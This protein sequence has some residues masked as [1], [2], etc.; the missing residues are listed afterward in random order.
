MV[1]YLGDK[2]GIRPGEVTPDGLF[3]LV[4]E[5]C[6]A[7]CCGAPMLQINDR[8]YENLTP[9][10]LDALIAKCRAEA[11]ADSEAQPHA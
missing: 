10:S 5:E 2:H 9:D 7:A 8:Y 3:S 1:R 6:L 11:R 4:T